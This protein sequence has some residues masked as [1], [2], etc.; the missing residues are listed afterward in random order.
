MAR[1]ADALA[2]LRGGKDPIEIAREMAISITTVCQYL[3]L[4]IGMGKLRRSDVWFSV[5]HDR[6]NAP[7]DR[8]YKD[9][10]NAMQMGRALTATCTTMSGL[11]KLCLIKS[12]GQFFSAPLDTVRLTGGEKAFHYP[13]ARNAQSGTKRT[14]SHVQNSMRTLT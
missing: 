12:F 11:S 14:K 4:N 5:S 9:L 8:S 6:R 3:E 10:W 7:P 13:F 2:L 1:H